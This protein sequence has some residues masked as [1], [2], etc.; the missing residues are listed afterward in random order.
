MDVPN[1]P[2]FRNNRQRAAPRPQ[3][4]TIT[5]DGV[6]TEQHPPAGFGADADAAATASID[7]PDRFRTTA[8][9]AQT[10]TRDTGLLAS[11]TLRATQNAGSVAKPSYVELDRQVLRFYSYFKEAVHE[12]PAEDARVRKC[13]IQFFLVDGT[14]MVIE[15]REENSGIPQGTFV[16]RHRIPKPNGE[17][18]D[19][20]D[21]V[22][23]GEITVYGRTLR[24]V[25]CDEFTRGFYA[26]RGFDQA[27]AEAY[28]DDPYTSLRS[29]MAVGAGDGYFGCKSN[30]LKKFME[31]SL[32][33][34]AA[35][36]GE[37]EN[38]RQ[39]LQ[40]DRKVLRFHCTW[41]DTGRLYGDKIAYTLHYFLADDTVEVREVPVMNSGRDNFPM[42]LRKQKLPKDW[43]KDLHND[44]SRGV[45]DNP[46]PGTYVL[47]EDLRVGGEVN[48]FGRTLKICACDAFTQK[49][50]RTNLR[51]EQ[52]PP[53]GASESKASDEERKSVPIPP[54]TGFGE[55][56]DSLASFYSLVPKPPK[57]DFN[58]FMKNDRKVLRF[59]ARL[60][61]A[62]P[63]DRHRSFIIQLY[64][65]DDTL[66]IYE[67]A[68]RNSGIVG[69]QFLVRNKY[70]KADGE[71]YGVQDFIPGQEITIYKRRFLVVDADEFTK[72]MYPALL[73][74]GLEATP[75]RDDPRCAAA[76]AKVRETLR[77]QG[78]HGIHGLAR[79]FRRMNENGDEGL[80]VDELTS[81]FKEVG[82]NLSEEEVLD[83]FNA[84][85]TNANGKISFEE[86]LAATR[87]GMNHR[88]LA[89]CHAAF[90]LLDSEGKGSVGLDDVVAK[91]DFSQNE[92]VLSGEQSV[93]DAAE[94]F[95]AQWDKLKVDGVIDREEFIEYCK[96]VSASIDSDDY[97]QL[98]M[99]K[100]WRI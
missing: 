66:A 61:R 1:L 15:H 88:R 50:Y 18:Y 8:Q 90:D 10:G 16:K 24:I 26:S 53:I 87:G 96:G 3:N 68:I 7:A 57:K 85:D 86:F 34:V 93:L 20:T 89:L 81:G 77:R 29:T 40:N 33:K 6:P 36:R 79:V 23:G 80:T 32:G 31:A 37:D 92:R 41:D 2:V 11:S 74:Q 73:P 70:R 44:A 75:A 39:F 49:W 14:A 91:Y 38:L 17:P 63:E 64:L 13:T 52:A 76:L 94:E 82:C 48:V 25:D 42:L 51:Y 5:R 55:E 22:V 58:K 12:S 72:K 27:A 97:F 45:E 100:A 98:V 83:V 35:G 9:L 60:A 84:F 59:S 71:T 19:W 78:M 43:K 69:G 46:P 21:L 47:P 62:C 99:K 95:V 30:P 54:Y 28:P 56:A 4:F 65:A 67:P